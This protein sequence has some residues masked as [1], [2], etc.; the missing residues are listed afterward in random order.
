MLPERVTR[1]L[2]VTIFKKFKFGYGKFIIT[3]YYVMGVKYL[4]IGHSCILIGN[5]ICWL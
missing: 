3:I 1:T 4:Q 5:K 2:L